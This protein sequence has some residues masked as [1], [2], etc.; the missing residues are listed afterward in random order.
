MMYSSVAK[1]LEKIFEN[2][3]EGQRKCL[4]YMDLADFKIVNMCYGYKSGEKLLDTLECYL[5]SIPG[6]LLCERMFADQFVFAAVI[7]KKKTKKKIISEYKYYSEKFVEK[8]GGQYPEYEMHS[9]CGICFPEN[10][11]F[12]EAIDNAHIAWMKAK[13]MK[14][15]TAVIYDRGILAELLQRKKTE[16]YVNMALKEEQFVF[17]LQPKVDL[18]TGQIIGAEAL[19][20]LLDPEGSIISPESFIGIMRDN[21]IISALDRLILKLVCKNLA[22]RLKKGLPVVP[23]AVNLSWQHVLV[24]DSAEYLHFIVQKYHIPPALVQFEMTET[25]LLEQFHAVKKLC[26]GL[27]S[28]GYTIAVDDFGAGYTDITAIQE[29]GFDLLKL[30]RKFLTNEEP[31]KSRNKVLMPDLIHSMRQFKIDTICEGVETKEQCA[32]LASVGCGQA[33][34]FYF[35]KP[36]SPQDFYAEFER[37]GGYYPAQWV[38][39]R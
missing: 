6:V 9:Y 23:I 12:L 10:E 8:Y 14:T 31:A 36:V 1:K 39:E 25:V 18:L 19:A 33:Q 32:Y 2:I 21:G 20:R 28:R 38:K 3:P 27:R 26:E 24:A 34:G 29:L 17:Y 4:Y 11:D 13:Q 5:K 7:D 30:D 16:V 37:L 15:N 22:L 35:S